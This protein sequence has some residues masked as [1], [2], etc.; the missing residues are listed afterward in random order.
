VAVFPADSP[1]TAFW[2]QQAAG[3]QCLLFGVGG[4]VRVV[5]A[6]WQ[7]HTWEVHAATPVGDLRYTLHIAGQH[8]VVNSLAAATCALAAGVPLAAIANGLAGFTPVK[9]RSRALVVPVQG[10]AVT[11][12]DDT[13]N[14]NPDSM[15]AAIEVLA[16]LPAPRLL[17]VGDMGEVGDQGPAFHREAGE[18]A[19]AAGIDKLLTLGEQ[20]RQVAAGFGDAG[21]YCPDIDTLNARVLALLPVAGSVLVKGS[22]F[23]KMERVVAAIE[24]AGTPQPPTTRQEGSTMAIAEKTTAGGATC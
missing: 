23:M 18:H 4:D 12:V 15:R 20:S 7:G 24:A 14:A 13:Y 17:V 3:R 16:A 1:Y 9:G 6:T 8:N 11:V 19:R 10:R 2:R 21:A 5:Q 22:R